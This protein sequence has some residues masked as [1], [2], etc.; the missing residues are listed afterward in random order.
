M[1]IHSTIGSMTTYRGPSDPASE[2]SDATHPD[3]GSPPGATGAKGS[4]ERVILVDESDAEIGTAGKREVHES[5]TLHRAFSVFLIDQHG[6]H[7]LQRRARHKYHSAG[8]WSNA[9]CSHPR[10]GES[11]GHAAARRLQEEIGMRA[12]IVPAFRMRYRAPMPNGLVEHEY[13]HVFIGSVDSS[14]EAPAPDPSEVS[15]ARFMKRESVER[16]IR[17]SPAVFTRWFLLAWPEVLR[18]LES[19]NPGSARSVFCPDGAVATFLYSQDAEAGSS[20]D[21]PSSSEV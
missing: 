1:R 3:S 9:C 8:L 16:M 13:D 18:H 10:P 21:S 6:R 14:A 4:D 12:D 17:E 15:E 7:L 11:T 19:G 5:G 2:P 20:T